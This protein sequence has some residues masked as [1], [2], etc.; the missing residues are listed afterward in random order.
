M[1]K[2]NK[3]KYSLIM[4]YC[5]D[6]DQL[7]F[8]EERIDALSHITRLVQIEKLSRKDFFRYLAERDDIAIS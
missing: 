6:E 7:E 1:T 4:E 5:P 3:L 2:K 8:I